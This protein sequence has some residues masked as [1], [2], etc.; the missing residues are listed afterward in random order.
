MFK[1]VFKFPLIIEETFSLKQWWYYN[2]FLDIRIWNP[3]KEEA[4]RLF[5]EQIAVAWELWCI[6]NEENVPVHTHDLR[7]RLLLIIKK[8]KIKVV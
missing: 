2:S 5:V 7:H 8:I 3:N 6:P 1:M 4:Y